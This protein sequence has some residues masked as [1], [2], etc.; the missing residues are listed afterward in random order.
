LQD[1]V[2]SFAYAQTHKNVQ[3]LNFRAK[4]ELHSDF[5]HVSEIT[6]PRYISEAWSHY[7]MGKNHFKI[8]LYIS[9]QYFALFQESTELF[10]FFLEK[11]IITGRKQHYN[12]VMYF[13][14]YVLLEEVITD[15]SK[16]CTHLSTH[17]DERKYHSYTHI[18]AN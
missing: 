5:N 6:S 18:N 4:V 9:L 12:S 8:L 10:F 3:L 17:C 13:L 15:N 16:I 11:T 2:C 1:Y 14:S 7:A